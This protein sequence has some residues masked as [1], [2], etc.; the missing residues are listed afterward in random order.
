MILTAYANYVDVKKKNNLSK[1]ADLCRFSKVLICGF[2]KNLLCGPDI[3][4]A[5][6]CAFSLKIL[7]AIL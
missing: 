6:L 5:D 1:Y 4:C 7:E 2:L 3:A